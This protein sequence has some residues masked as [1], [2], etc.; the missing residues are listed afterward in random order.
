MMGGFAMDK[1][2][3]VALPGR[4]YDI[5][6]G[7]GL[8]AR[9]GAHIA[10]LAGG[11]AVVVVSDKTVWHLYGAALNAALAGAGLRAAPVVVPPG[12]ESKSL[13][14]LQQ[15]YQGFAE[16][17]L[18][19]DGL[20]LAL[21]GGVVGDLAGFAAA[22]WMRGVRYVQLPT[23]LLAQ[24]DSSVGGKTAVNLPVGKNLAGAFHQPQLVLAD[25]A[26]LDTLP[27]QQYACGMAEVIKCGAIRDKA[28]FAM[29]SAKEKAVDRTAMI[30]TCCGIKR[31]IVQRDERDTGERAL[32]NFG[33][34]LGH[35]VETLGGY[36]HFNH[37]QAVA[38]GM[39][40][41]AKLGRQM[42]RTPPGL[43]ETLENTLKQW[44]LPAECP[45]SL[46]EMTPQLALD[47]K[48]RGAGVQMI[49]LEDIGRA[50]VADV[51][52]DELEN[53]LEKVMGA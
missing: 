8:L 12:E 39:V 42:G 45:Y 11:G 20:V 43:P 3:H 23:T 34:T 27:P 15:V 52:L 38:I 16:A 47:K 44:N 36:S 37:G 32:L 26:A 6:I 29:L 7:E 5:I 18:A 14:C 4:S 41:A 49:L 40:L 9:V 53:L 10:G 28:L 31:D 24:V 35:A 30:E 48:R 50:V 1:T 22:T 21:G 2:V 51:P 46:R 33:H 17:G 13:A 25:T 19:R